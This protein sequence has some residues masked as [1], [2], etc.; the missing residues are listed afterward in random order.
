MARS[1][2]IF[3]LLLPMVLLSCSGKLKTINLQVGDKTITVEIADN[4]ATRE[5]GLMNRR[6][7]EPDHGMLFV[8]QEEKKL[9]FWMKNTLIPLSIAYISKSGEI[10]EIYDMY[11]LDET[12]IR[13]SRYV[14]Y[15]LEMNQGWFKANGIKPGDRIILP[16]NL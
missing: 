7:M 16:Q 14:L 3:I 9:S 5:K 15:A 6:S 8:F 1:K 4:D 12:P 13:S 10:K 2:I 11:P